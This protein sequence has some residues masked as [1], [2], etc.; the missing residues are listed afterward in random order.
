MVA[1]KIMNNA[2]KIIIVKKIRLKVYLKC[3]KPKQAD[4]L[5]AVVPLFCK[6]YSH[7]YVDVEG[8]LTFIFSLLL[9][10]HS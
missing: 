1:P 5:V 9:P 7:C 8:K 6:T 2:E 4:T 10:N 3:L